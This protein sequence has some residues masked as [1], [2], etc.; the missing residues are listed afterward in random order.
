VTQDLGDRYW[1]KVDAAGDCWVWVGA[2]TRAGYGN[3]YMDGRNHVAHRV[4][5][6]GLVGAVPDGLQLDHRCRNRA[7]VNPAH[8]D[9]VTQQENLLR[10]VGASARHAIKTHCPRGHAYDQ[11]N[12]MRPPT[13][14]RHCLACARDRNR[15]RYRAN[16]SAA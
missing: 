16:R 14:G 10:G 13:G 6:E 9:P 7:C 3:Y 5:W 1:S 8:L 11:A 15:A 4:A 12:T 2:R